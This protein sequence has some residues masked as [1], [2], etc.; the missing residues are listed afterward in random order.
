MSLEGKQGLAVQKYL[1]WIQCVG[2]QTGQHSAKLV[3]LHYNKDINGCLSIS[4]KI[5]GFVE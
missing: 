4:L 5:N 1:L 3:T 2:L